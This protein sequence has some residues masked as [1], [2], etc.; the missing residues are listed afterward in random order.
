MTTGPAPASPEPDD[1]QA[2]LIKLDGQPL[3]AQWLRQLSGLRIDR[4]LGLVGRATLRFHDPGFAMSSS[5]VFAL[6]KSVA[7]TTY[8]S[9]TTLMSG[10]VT[11]LT[12]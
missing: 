1:G 7:F 8:K 4:G 10:T 2:P 9:G 11:G 3:Q 5:A 12:L 6:G